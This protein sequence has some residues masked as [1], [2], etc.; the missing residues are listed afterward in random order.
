MVVDSGILKD[1]SK[2]STKHEYA[3]IQSAHISFWCDE[4]LGRPAKENFKSSDV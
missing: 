3:N 1:L 2:K 4:K